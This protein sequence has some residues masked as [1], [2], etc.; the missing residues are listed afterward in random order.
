[1]GHFDEDFQEWKA[2]ENKDKSF[3]NFCVLI[4]KQHKKKKYFFTQKIVL[5]SISYLLNIQEN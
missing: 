5:K 4:P 3:P 2:S 1:M